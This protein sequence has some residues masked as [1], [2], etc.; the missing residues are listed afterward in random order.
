V[1]SE[2]LILW[3]LVGNKSTHLTDVTNASR[4]MLMNLRTL[5]WDDE[6]CK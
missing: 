3:N 4:T 2:Q 1:H 5:K 6:L